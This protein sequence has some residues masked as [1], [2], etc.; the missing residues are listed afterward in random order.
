MQKAIAAHLIPAQIG[1]PLE[2][3]FFNGLYVENGQERVSIRAGKGGILQG[4]WLPSY[5][6]V[7]GARSYTDSL[8]NTIAMAEAGSD[9]AKQF[10]ALRLGGHEDWGIAARDILELLY[11]NNKPTARK[12]CCSFRDGDN[13]SSLPPGYPYTPDFPAQVAIPE[14]QEG[15]ELALPADWIV[16]STESSDE[17]AWCQYFYYGC[18]YDFS[19]GYE[20]FAVAVRSLAVIR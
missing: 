1:A 17:Y 14:F 2:G 10:L 6:A 20:A 12:N 8:A 5:T 18:Q 3:G 11:R 16:S 15:G 19:K 4:V 13:P 9:L 7:P